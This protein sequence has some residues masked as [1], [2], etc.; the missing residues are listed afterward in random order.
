MS[1]KRPFEGDATG[2]PSSKKPRTSG[3]N[4]PSF[5]PPKNDLQQASVSD[6]V[7]S[8][9]SLSMACMP[10]SIQV[11][12]QIAA[13]RAEV[14][15]KLAK[16]KASAQISS[17]SKAAAPSTV[18]AKE[19]LTAAR[20]NVSEMARRVEEAKRKVEAM[21]AKQRT[22]NS[23][24]YLSSS[25]SSS[26][27]T[28]STLAA[29]AAA[30]PGP[31]GIHPLLMDMSVP[32]VPQSKKDRYKP[33]QPKFASTKANV[34]IAQAPAPP[35]KP[36]DLEVAQ[37]PTL[38]EARKDP[39]FDRRLGVETL[40]P[41]VK[42]RGRQLRFNQKGKFTK[43]GD[44]MRQEAK[45]EALKQRIMETARKAGLEDEMESA[46]GGLGRKIKKPTPPAVEWWDAKFLLQDS[47]DD[48]D[49]PQAQLIWENG[50]DG[51]V[52]HPIPIPAPGDN[53]QIPIK[54][55]MLTKKVRLM[56]LSV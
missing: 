19:D 12:Q 30:A 42:K 8:L 41:R 50:C 37:A 34:R 2:S 33:M 29:A 26:K 47:Y 28:T 56:T 10:T 17:S 16:I 15:A 45:M 44:Q 32:A 21:A 7:R 4:A 11:A 27:L 54:A 20:P 22:S 38:E 6:V 1:S 55:L 52:Q 48:L 39:H 5:L 51:L 35:P 49:L 14:Q 18:T 13:K 46:E 25:S 43:L 53:K 36:R 24:P 23:N 40:V 31:G 9:L 3:S